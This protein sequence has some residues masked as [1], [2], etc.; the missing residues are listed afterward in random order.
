MG[1]IIGIGQ[2]VFKPIPANTLGVH[3]VLNT[4]AE[5]EALVLR[6]SSQ[7]PTTVAQLQALQTAGNLA[8]AP[9]FYSG[10]SG[11]R[12]F[13]AA[14]DSAYAIGFTAD[15][16][17]G[18]YV[19][20]SGAFE[21]L[22]LEG[23][24]GT[25]VFAEDFIIS[26][27]NGK[28]F[29][30][31]SDGQTVP[32]SNK[33][34]KEVILLAAIEDVYPTYNPARLDFYQSAPA[35]GEIGESLA[36]TLT[37]QFVRNDAGALGQI[38]IYRDNTQVGNNGADNANPFAK[39]VQ[40]VRSSVP[41]AVWATADYAAGAKKVVRP[42]NRLDDRPA[43]V[44]SPN[45]PQAAEIGITSQIRYYTGY[46]KVFLGP[47]TS[48]PTTSTQVRNLAQFQ[49]TVNGPKVTLQTGT[50]ALIFVVVLPPGFSLKTVF[51]LDNQSA[52]ITAS[53]RFKGTLSVQDAK[54]ASSS[55]WSVY[56]LEAATPYTSSARH[57][58]SYGT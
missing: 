37:A 8:V 6:R 44:R 20:S 14:A 55:G 24:T 27:S 26:L 49:L 4:R 54:G 52:N 10:P 46:Y 19:V 36:N 16:V 45:A 39:S 42:S 7:Q 47:V 35:D 40:M 31:F 38:R 28:S 56:A 57:E 13:F 30:R 41:S 17:I 23:G 11:V 50:T 51:D 2:E 12:L 9:T 53:Y 58:I 29:G 1:K 43:Q 18:R 15:G 48:I 3:P 21:P 33:T 32:A 34:A 5:L 22:R 25:E